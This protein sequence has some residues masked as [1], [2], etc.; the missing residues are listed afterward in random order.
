M[1]KNIRKAR[2]NRLRRLVGIIDDPEEDGSSPD[3]AMCVSCM[4]S[5]F[6]RPGGALVNVRN[7]GLVDLGVSAGNF[8]CG[9][10]TDST[11]SYVVCI[12]SS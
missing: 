12:C 3:I 1:K 2:V 11:R 6:C 4:L 8:C 7:L 5:L 10:K 9:I